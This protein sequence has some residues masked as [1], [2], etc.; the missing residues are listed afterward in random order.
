MRVPDLVNRSRLLA[1][2]ALVP[3]GDAFGNPFRRFDGS[4]R[5]NPVTAIYTFTFDKSSV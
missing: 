4:N 1:T 5:V 2:R 3:A